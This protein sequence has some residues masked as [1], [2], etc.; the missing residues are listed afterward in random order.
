MVHL[1][2]A[3]KYIP[4]YVARCSNN[5]NCHLGVNHWLSRVNMCACIVLGRDCLNTRT[6]CDPQ[7]GDVAFQDFPCLELP[8]MVEGH[9]FCL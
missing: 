8:A 2:L 3:R 5:A 1:R 9:D 7:V 6:Y 4:D